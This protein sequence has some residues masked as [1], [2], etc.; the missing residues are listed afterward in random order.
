MEFLIVQRDRLPDGVV[1]E[2]AA[3]IQLV[4]VP[5]KIVREAADGLGCRRLGRVDA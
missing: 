4:I 1:R 2:E 3:R 5:Q